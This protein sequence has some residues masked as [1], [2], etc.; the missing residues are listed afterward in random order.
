MKI[1]NS[2]LTTLMIG[3]GL[4]G[5][6]LFGKNTPKP[7]KIAG[8]LT[9]LVAG[10]I[11]VRRSFKSEYKK[12]EKQI[13]EVNE[14]FEETGL[15]PEKVENTS[16]LTETAG[17]TPIFAEILLKEIWNNAVLPDEILEY[18]KSAYLSTL[19][20]MQNTDKNRLIVSIPLPSKTKNNLGPQEIREYYKQVFED[21]IEEHNL[22]MKNY[23]NQIG[24]VV[25]IGNE[26]PPY[27]Y[28]E[29]IV[30]EDGEV[31]H[32]YNSR[33]Q[34]YL[35]DSDNGKAP[36]GLVIPK[37]EQFLRIE[38]Y[39]NLEFPIF[40]K[41]SNRI[42]LDLFSAVKLIKMLLETTSIRSSSG[43]DC[44]FTLDR[45]AFHPTDDYGTILVIDGGEMKTIDL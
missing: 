1:K 40:P 44:D 26:N 28:Y 23:L 35:R 4:V 7:L 6:D 19:H 12:L 16:L 21:F 9:S 14:T 15:N 11:L 8:V 34:T 17:G 20:I 36:R 39:L 10:G 33:I 29:E 18:N 31:F 30:R 42:G 32:E 41:N 5:L 37:D 2:I 25:T 45:I 3:G 38:Q 24:V 43:K 13:E 22:D 27:T